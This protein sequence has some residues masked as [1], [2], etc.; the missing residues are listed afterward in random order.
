MDYLTPALI[1]IAEII[2]N[3]FTWVD[4]TSR[5]EH[6]YWKNPGS[7][8]LGSSGFMVDPIPT[9]DEK[10]TVQVWVSTENIGYMGFCHRSGDRQAIPFKLGDKT[11]AVGVVS[12]FVEKLPK[13]FLDTPLEILHR[14]NPLLVSPSKRMTL[15]FTHSSKSDLWTPDE[16]WI[17]VS[18][19]FLSRSSRNGPDCRGIPKTVGELLALGTRK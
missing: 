4:W 7:E 12:I 2:Q 10:F 6:L 9:S 16:N 11:E 1:P 13:E 3:V 5:E 19:W 18:P 8:S 14:H 17:L 15:G